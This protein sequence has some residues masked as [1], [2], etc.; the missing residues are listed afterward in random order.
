MKHIKLLFFLILLYPFAANGG[1]GDPVFI[2]GYRDFRGFLYIFENG[3]P[4]QLEQQPVRSFKAKGPFIA[5][6][7][8]ANDLMVYF[9]GEK[10][11]LGDMTATS[12]D[13]TQ[14]LMYFQRDLLLSVFDAGKVTPLTFFLRDYKV[15]DSLLAFRD[16]N[17]DILRVY[18]RGQIHDL[19]FTLTGSLADYK[20]G[21]NTVA[22][23]NNTGFFKA[24]MNDHLYDIDNIAP[25]AYEP[26]GNL[27]GYVDGLYNYL[28]VFYNEKILVLERFKPV[29]F[30]AGVEVLAYISD[31]NA[32]KVFNRGKLL[33][34]EAYAPD[35][36]LVRD[37]SVLFFFN[38]QLQVLS[39]GV[40]YTLDEFM[41]LNY[42]LSEN[43]IAWTDQAG[44]LHIFTE[45]KS[46]EVSLERITS[47]EL[48]GNTL[49]YDLPDGTSRIWYRG[50]VY[51]NN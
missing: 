23:V 49:K 11:K 36:Y 22:Y 15:S 32:F 29:S 30:Q 19:E 3:V 1:E 2:Q 33:K 18:A 35:F 25:E 26:G 14:S 41:P 6:A 40:R 27:V 43:N 34:V 16:R 31:E 9:N 13:L 39:D 42:Q 51:G 45:G 37:R 8:S 24:Y 12:F 47:Y 46:Y 10:F 38:N 44:R 7:N 50:K 5:Y 17:V 48:N 28:K 21:E 20:I 4:R